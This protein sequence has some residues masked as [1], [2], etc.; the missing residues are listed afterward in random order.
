MHREPQCSSPRSRGVHLVQQLLQLQRGHRGVQHD[1]ASSSSG[2]SCGHPHRLRLSLRL[3]LH[4]RLQLRIRGSGVALLVPQVDER[5]GGH[6][7]EGGHGHPV[8]Q[9]GGAP[10]LHVGKH[11]LLLSLHHRCGRHEG[12]GLA[13]H[14]RLALLLAPLARCLAVPSGHHRQSCC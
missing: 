6:E 7:G 11:G 5:E 10:V 8:R 13:V 3:R 2:S 12:V 14:A 9:G 1:L 4:L